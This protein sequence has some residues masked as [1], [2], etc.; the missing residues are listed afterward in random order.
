MNKEKKLP[1]IKALLSIMVKH[2]RSTLPFESVRS[3]FGIAVYVLSEYCVF[4][5]SC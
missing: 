1:E 2:R 5:P 3:N 4:L